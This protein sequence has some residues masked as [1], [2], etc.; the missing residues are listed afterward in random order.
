MLRAFVLD[1]K[2]PWDN[3]VPFIEFA[4]NNS[5]QATIQMALYEALYRKKCRSTIC[6]DEVGEA[7]VIGDYLRG[8]RISQ[9]HTS[10]DDYDSK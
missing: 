8:D 3:H 1:F 7:K 9:T 10:K 5:E 6:W 2:G 4:Y